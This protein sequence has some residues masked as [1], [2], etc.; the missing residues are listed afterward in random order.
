MESLLLGEGTL[1]CAAAV[2]GAAVLFGSPAISALGAETRGFASPNRFEFA[3]VGGVRFKVDMP[4]PPVPLDVSGSAF[5]GNNEPVTVLD[6][7]TD[8]VE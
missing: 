4:V 7:V 1:R 3:F 8:T 6:V 2:G 5:Y